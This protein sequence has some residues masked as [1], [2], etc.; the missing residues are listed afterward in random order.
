[1]QPG[2]GNWIAHG[3]AELGDNRLL[4]FMHGIGRREKDDNPSEN[5]EYYKRTCY[6]FHRSFSELAFPDLVTEAARSAELPR[7]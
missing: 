5:E 2:L 6:F 4:G 1:M 3:F 7:L